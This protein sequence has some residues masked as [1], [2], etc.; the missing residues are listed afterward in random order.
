MCVCD[1][2]D[3]KKKKNNNN[4]YSH[5]DHHHNKSNNHNSNNNKNENDN[6]YVHIYTYIHPCCIGFIMH[7]QKKCLTP[8]LP[9]DLLQPLLHDAGSLLHLVPCIPI[10]RG[11]P[12]KIQGKGGGNS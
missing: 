6:I 4:Y 12:G 3:D 8:N 11:N 10:I 7:L 2:D 5:N 9:I 1:D